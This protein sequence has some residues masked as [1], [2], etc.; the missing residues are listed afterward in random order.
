MSLLEIQFV[1]GA[2]EAAPLHSDAQWIS[3]WKDV[4]KAIDNLPMS[5][6]RPKLFSAHVMGGCAMSNEA[7]TGVVDLDGLHYHISN[8]SIIDGSI[9]P[10][11]IGA[12]PSLAI[13]AM[14]AKLANSLLPSLLKK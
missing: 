11:S 12:N 7:D 13:Y 1:A 6:L 8:L 9:F 5:A 14:A 2:I 10:T 3:S 4:R